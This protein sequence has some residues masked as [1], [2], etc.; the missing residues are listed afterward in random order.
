[1][2]NLETKLGKTNHIIASTE[3]SKMTLLH[4]TAKAGG[5]YCDVRTR[6]HDVQGAFSKI[7]TVSF[8]EFGRISGGSSVIGFPL[9]GNEETAA[10]PSRAISATIIIPVTLGTHRNALIRRGLIVKFARVQSCTG[11]RP[12][13]T[14]GSG[15]FKTAALL[16]VIFVQ[17]PAKRAGPNR[18]AK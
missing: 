2:N 13:A 5:V 18:T 3:K 8:A 7:I 12:T 11:R 17:E 4:S 9:S 15:K 14:A 1:V 10:T 6:S 16:A